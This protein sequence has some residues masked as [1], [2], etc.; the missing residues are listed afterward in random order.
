MAFRELLL[1]W[2]AVLEEFLTLALL[3]ENL[4][5]AM[6][7]CLARL[8]RVATLLV[9]SVGLRWWIALRRR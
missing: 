3:A 4:K 1:A 6:C 5:L 7:I 8:V 2:V 9:Q